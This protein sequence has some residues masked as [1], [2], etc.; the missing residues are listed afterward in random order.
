MLALVIWQNHF[1]SV[2]VSS[3][4]AMRGMAAKAMCGLRTALAACGVLVLATATA[5]AEDMA[6]SVTVTGACKSQMFAGWDDLPGNC[7]LYGLQERQI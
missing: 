2:G 4:E 3:K 5:A 1:A 6:Y 7:H